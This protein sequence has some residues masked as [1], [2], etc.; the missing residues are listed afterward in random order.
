M[1]VREVL[2][3]ARVSDIPFSQGRIG[4]FAMFWPIVEWHR[5]FADRGT[6]FSFGSDPSVSRPY[7]SIWV[8]SRLFSGWPKGDVFEALSQLRTATDR[9]VW[10]DAADSTG[11][12][13][14]EFAAQVDVYAKRHLLSDP[15]VYF[16]GGPAK[17]GHQLY[18]DG[19]LGLSPAPAELTHPLCMDEVSKVRLLWSFAFFERPLALRG[20]RSFG[21]LFRASLGLRSRDSGSRPIPIVGALFHDDRERTFAAVR[22]LAQKHVDSGGGLTLKGRVSRQVYLRLLH[23][24]D[25]S[26]SPFGHGEYCYRDFETL[27]AGATLAKPDVS[28]AR[29]FPDILEAGQSYIPLSWDPSTWMDEIAQ[30]EDWQAVG[31]EGLRRMR[32]A[33][34][35]SG[36][37]EFVTHVEIC[38]LGDG[39]CPLCRGSWWG[40][41]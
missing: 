18:F 6:I 37:R 32:A 40:Q 19:L 12:T 41:R 16:S 11:H 30:F 9:L 2:I 15:S 13:H 21:R 33:I 34:S 26:I 22:R 23:K 35:N 8:S 27:L 17:P 31:R 39:L 7:D 4:P 38:I 28:N 14:F 24:V 25:I 5:L 20:H 29:T 1:R 10:L 36:A 3:L